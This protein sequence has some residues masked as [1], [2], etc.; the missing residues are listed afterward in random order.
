MIVLQERVLQQPRYFFE[1]VV[2]DGLPRTA[3]GARF[4]VE[5]D[6]STPRH[7]M[8]DTAFAVISPPIAKKKAPR[9]RCAIF[10]M[11]VG[12]GFEPSKA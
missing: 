7:F 1:M 12:D 4:A 11:V 3:Y 6:D 8:P 2:G 9:L 5:P 10:A